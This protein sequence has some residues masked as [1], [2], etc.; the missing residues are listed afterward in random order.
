M[1]ECF[2]RKPSAAILRPLPEVGAVAPATLLVEAAGPLGC[3]D[4]AAFRALSGVAS[5]TTHRQDRCQGMLP[6]ALP[7][8]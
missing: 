2:G 1:G 6:V 3:R 8:A 7:R 5:V 4:Y